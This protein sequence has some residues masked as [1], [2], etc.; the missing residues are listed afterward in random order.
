MATVWAYRIGAWSDAPST[1]WSHT[2]YFR[3]GRLSTLIE[4][5]GDE[6]LRGR[7]SRLAIVAHGDSG[8]VVQL[9]PRLTISSMT[10]FRTDFRRLRAYLTPNAMLCFFSC[11]AGAGDEG[12]ELLKAVSLQFPGCTIA[13]FVIYGCYS[14]PFGS[15]SAPGNMFASST[16]R[17]TLLANS[18][19]S[20]WDEHCKWA[21]QGE[22][23]R[24]PVAE[25]G[26]RTNF[27]CGNPNC[28]G[29]R[30]PHHRCEGWAPTGLAV[31]SP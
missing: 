29:H 30:S 22:V 2:M 28:G 4:E 21:Y 11:I 6:G 12:S 31:H 15:L 19:M 25:Q 7:V 5:L 1:G 8:G 10:T 17:C 9:A 23:V 14:N 18:T 27:T 16:S 26:L 13:G 20:P 3:D 24:W